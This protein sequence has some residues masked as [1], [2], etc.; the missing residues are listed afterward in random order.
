M[1]GYIFLGLAIIIEIFSTS[2]LK[3]SEGFSRLL[4]SIIFAVGMGASF[5]TL[6]QALNSIPLSIAYAIWSGLGTAL[7][8]VVAVVVWKETITMYTGI[9]ILLI[10][11]G[12]VILNVKGTAH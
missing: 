1:N 8:A 9:G 7:T 6:S 4:P 12:V 11:L 10:I 3:A 5:Y 2:M